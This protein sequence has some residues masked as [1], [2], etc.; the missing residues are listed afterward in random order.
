MSDAFRLALPPVARRSGR[1]A[2][3][4]PDVRPAMP[5]D[6]A[7]DVARRCRH[8]NSLYPPR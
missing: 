5:A 8:R 4:R 2:G 7:A 1:F 3:G 6:Y